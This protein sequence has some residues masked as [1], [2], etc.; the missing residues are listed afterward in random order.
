MLLLNVLM[1]A[2]F[3]CSFTIESSSLYEPDPCP[4]KILYFPLIFAP[5]RFFR[6]MLACLI[7]EK[8]S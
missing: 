1:K 5:Q 7:S 8:Q 6:S 3:I 4:E 2:Y